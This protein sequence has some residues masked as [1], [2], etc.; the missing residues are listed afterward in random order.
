MFS[1]QA[2]RAE[3]SEK[4]KGRRLE[5][6]E[7]IAQR[8]SGLANPRILEVGCVRSENAWE[9]DGQSTQIWNWMVCDNLGSATS[10]DIDEVSV[11]LAERLCPHVRVIC[12]DG[13]R[14]LQHF[15][16]KNRLDLVF[17]DG[18]D[19]TGP[20]ALKAWIQHAQFLDAVWD[21]LKPGALLAIDDCVDDGCGK[22]IFVKEFLS[23]SGIHPKVSSYIHVWEKP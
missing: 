13:S 17:L 15:Q 23:R 10:V 11:R 14:F 12:H 2:W 8:L 6:F 5:G 18:M 22:H 4:L 16:S 7:Y 19:F 21:D 9:A 3:F 1:L 20:H